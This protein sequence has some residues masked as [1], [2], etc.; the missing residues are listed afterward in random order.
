MRRFSEN[1][2]QI[3]NK[4][5]IQ[6]DY[7]FTLVD[8][9]DVAIPNNRYVKIFEDKNSST[10]KIKQFRLLAESGK[11]ASNKD[12]LLNLFYFNEI[13]EY[14]QKE[15]LIKVIDTIDFNEVEINKS[16]STGKP[17]WIMNDKLRFNLF[18]KL[19]YRYQYTHELIQL[20]NDNFI[21]KEEKLSLRN[22]KIAFWATI[23]TLISA[24][25]AFYVLIS[26]KNTPTPPT[27]VT[28]IHT[29]TIIKKP[30]NSNIMQQETE[31]KDTISH[32]H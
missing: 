9:I 12:I 5:L 4:I 29:D 6:N 3:I 17:S 14:L 11:D 16:H 23:G 13:I 28:I 19:Y 27:N 20:K 30:T 22:S 31:N 2:K 21:S 26:P 8:I 25:C 10:D 18:N 1:D 15:N 24:A 32:S 7:G